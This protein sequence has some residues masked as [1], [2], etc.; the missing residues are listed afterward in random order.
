MKRIKLLNFIVV[1]IITTLLTTACV[2]VKRSNT[3]VWDNHIVVV[4][5]I[6][7]SVEINGKVK[8]VAVF[9]P[10]AGHGLTMLD[11][12]IEIVAVS[13][14][15]KRDVLLEELNPSLTNAVIAGSGKEVNI[16]TL[17]AQNPDLIIVTKN[18][19]SNEGEKQKLDHS[20]IPY[21]VI[22]YSNIREQQ[23]VI[24]M[25][26]KAIGKEERA[27]AYNEFYKDTVSLVKKSVENMP[28]PE[29]V[30]VFHSISEATRTEIKGTISSDWINTAGLMNV[31]ED[32][33]LNIFENSKYFAS[34]EQIYLW[35]PDA[36]L[37]NDI[38]TAKY[39]MGDDKWAGLSAVKNQKV[40]P[41]PTGISRWGHVSSLEIPLVLLWTGKIFYPDKFSHIDLNQQIKDYYKNFFDYEVSDKQVES[42]LKAEGMRLKK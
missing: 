41:L 42:I 22:D 26:G 1:L 28:E 37:V 18:M 39:I 30:R 3:M 21:L 7:R 15:L 9:Y 14:G 25:L 34:L 29:R 4:D 8:K 5:S 12:D 36:F 33:K 40:Y 13:Q 6:G 32:E 17:M 20:N 11:R 19:V 35:D 24:A 27:K 16:E 23:D 10:L 2:G 38:E 31:I